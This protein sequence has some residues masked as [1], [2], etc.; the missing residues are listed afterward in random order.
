MGK[1]KSISELL[2]SIGFTDG[3]YLKIDVETVDIPE[4]AT[5]GFFTK[6]MEE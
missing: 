4:D 6:D 2:A 1:S 5:F 3:K